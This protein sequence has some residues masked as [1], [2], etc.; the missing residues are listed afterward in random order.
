MRGVGGNQLDILSSCFRRL[1]SSLVGFNFVIKHV[2][3]G[4]FLNKDGFLL[5]K[6]LHYFFSFTVSGEHK[7]ELIVKN[8]RCYHSIFWVLRLWVIIVFIFKITFNLQNF[9]S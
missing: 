3:I 2:Y 4:M 7:S 6:F 9:L 1:K 8:V 5:E